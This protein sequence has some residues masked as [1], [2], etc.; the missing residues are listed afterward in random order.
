MT[1]IMF[2]V[3]LLLFP[4]AVHSMSIN[5][6]P[7]HAVEE[8]VIGSELIRTSIV[9]D[10]PIGY[11]WEFLSD[12]SNA[13][14]WSSIFAKI[15]DIESSSAAGLPA[16]GTGERRRCQRNEEPVGLYW[17]EETALVGTDMMFERGFKRIFTFDWKNQRW[18]NQI[19][20]DFFGAIAYTDNLYESLTPNR[21]KFTFS[22]TILYKTNWFWRTLLWL[23]GDDAYL[24]ESFMVNQENIKAMAEARFTNSEYVRP[25]AYWLTGKIGDRSLTVPNASV[26]AKPPMGYN[27]HLDLIKQYPVLFDSGD[28]L[29]A[30]ESGS[31]CTIT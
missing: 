29:V 1:E 4:A 28:T 25:N 26:T 23:K 9:V 13:A 17:D 30:C 3:I 2:S 24:R 31:S 6:I 8:S 11:L 7:A 14:D 16:D 12:N 5:P 22:S 21:T 10:V 27:D 18:W 19:Q 15:F 20:T